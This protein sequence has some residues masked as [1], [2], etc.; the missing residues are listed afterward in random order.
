V[1]LSVAGLLVIALE[2]GVA[3]EQW[4]RSNVHRGYAPPGDL[5][6]FAGARSH[7]HCVGDGSP[8]VILEAGLDLN[9]SFSWRNV[10]NDVAVT[11]RV[12]SYDRAGIL[13]S[14]PR[15]GPRDAHRIADE[16]HALLSAAAER[17]PYVMVGHSTGGLL[18][19]VFAHRFKGQVVGFVLIDSAHPEQVARMPRVMTTQEEPP[20]LATKLF[21]LGTRFF[22][23]TGVT[24]LMTDPPKDPPQAFALRSMPGVRA[25][26]QAFEKMSA[27]AA[28]TGTLG[29][30]PL[31]VLT[32]GLKVPLPGTSEET[33]NTFHNTRFALQAELAKL[34]RNADH[35][36]SPRAGHYVQLDDPDAVVTAIKDVVIAV[37]ERA[38]VRKLSQ[39]PRQNHVKHSAKLRESAPKRAEGPPAQPPDLDG[40]KRAAAKLS[41]PE[42]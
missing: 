13:W 5:V 26:S 36:T 33:H 37:F 42:S 19:R 38:P 29:N 34:S 10:Q 9:G 22:L 3:Y 11:T 32:A 25:E 12:C 35:R 39:H 17:P 16:L 24:R 23:A 7:L 6:E 18:V 15:P 2:V 20:R 4:S 21:N 41:L 30:R 14:E 1:S 27:Q 40:A 8:T 31:V 28:V